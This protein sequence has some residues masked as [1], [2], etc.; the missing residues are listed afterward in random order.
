MK[1]PEDQSPQDRTTLK[2]V[3]RRQVTPKP[4]IRPRDAKPPKAKGPDGLRLFRDW[5]SI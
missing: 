1:R 4:V 5:A 3:P 2:P